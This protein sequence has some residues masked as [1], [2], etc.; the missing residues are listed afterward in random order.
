[1]GDDHLLVGWGASW[2]KELSELGEAEGGEDAGNAGEVV[3]RS[4]LVDAWNV[5]G[6]L[7]RVVAEVE[8]EGLVKGECRVHTVERDLWDNH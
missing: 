5:W 8:V 3:S 6:P 4:L 1:M 7:L 2:R